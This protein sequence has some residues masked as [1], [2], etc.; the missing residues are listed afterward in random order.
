MAKK[1]IDIQL[2]SIESDVANTTVQL[3]SVLVALNNFQKNGANKSYQI[4]L[5][6][7][8]QESNFVSGIVITEQIKDLPPKRNRDTGAFSSLGLQDNERLAYG[9]A[10]LYDKDLKVIFYEVNGNGCYLD[11]FS[12]MIKEE[13]NSRQQGQQNQIVDITF[14]SIPKNGGYQ[15]YLSM[16]YLKEFVLEVACPH[17][18]IQEYQNRNRTLIG[19]ITPDL[20]RAVSNNAD[21]MQIRYATLGKKA[22]NQG[23]DAGRIR[24]LVKAGQFILTGNQRANVRELKVVGFERSP[25]GRSHR[26]TAD[27]ITDLLKGSIELPTVN[28][29]VDLQEASRQSQIEALHSNMRQNIQTILQPQQI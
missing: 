5:W 25:E 19:A 14:A 10:F 20:N 28:Q 24:K 11:Q 3:E 17:A 12:A 13:W 15:Q 16:Y 27:L 4:K 9:N 22:N 6:N 29:H 21:V 8:G 7:N 23:L 18:I 2:L 26:T 1:M